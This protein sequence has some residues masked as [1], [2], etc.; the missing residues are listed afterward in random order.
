M[1]QLVARS[2]WDAEVVR[3]S[4]I[5][6]TTCEKELSGAVFYSETISYNPVKFWLDF[7]SGYLNLFDLFV[8]CYRY[9]FAI[10]ALV[11][12]YVFSCFSRV[13]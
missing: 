7:L 10:R 13:L 3:S 2:V 6:P 5:T 11:I 4:R 12:T 1:A 8:R 9:N